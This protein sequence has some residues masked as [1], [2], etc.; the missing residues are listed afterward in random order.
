MKEFSDPADISPHISGSKKTVVFFE[1]TGCP[2]C[3]TCKS[4]VDDLVRERSADIDFV[5]VLLDAPNGPLWERYGIRAVPTVIAFSRGEIVARA[6]SILGI[7]LSK[8]KWADFRA[9]I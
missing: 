7:G 4:R 9:T 3:I 1:M 8:K 2:F 5:R 6:D